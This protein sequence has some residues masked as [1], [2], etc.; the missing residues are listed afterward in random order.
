MKGMT[1]TRR[2]FLNAVSAA[3]FAGSSLRFLCRQAE[4]A[5]L[6]RFLFAYTSA[7]R[8]F[9]SKSTGTGTSFTLGPGLAALEPFK[10][11]ISVV[12]GLRIPDHVE[13]EHPDGRSSMLTGF[14][15]NGRRG[16]GT[17]IDRYLAN[18]LTAGASVYTGAESPGGN[19]DVP[20]SWQANTVANEG[21]TQGSAALLSKLLGGSAP[22]S[23]P[24]VTTPTTPTAP[25]GPSAAQLKAKNEQALYDHLMAQVKSLKNVAPKAELE[26]IEL[27]ITAL[28]QARSVYDG[29]A[30]GGGGT[31][32][33][34]GGGGDSTPV[35]PPGDCSMPNIG[36]ASNESEKLA[37]VMAHAFACGRSRIGVVRLGTEEPHHDWSHYVA[38]NAEYEKLR[39]LDKT[40][41]GYFAKLL[42][43]LDSF[44]EGSGTVLDNTIVVW[45]SEVSGLFG[46]EDIHDVV[47]M[48]VLLAGGLGGKIKMGQRIVAQGRYTMELYRAI[49]RAMGAGDAMD[50]GDSK[51]SNKIL[52]DVLA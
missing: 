2:R 52:E 26:K 23:P 42:G 32:P 21:F 46:S 40:E 44:K 34:P 33:T 17:S 6:P 29:A 43:Y 13:E 18:K 27:H 12:D 4:G 35:T 15:S 45:S 47:N 22:S 14:R 19:I 10:S 31:S 5:G 1:I 37:L 30:T 48:P 39:D 20:I 3:T 7:G 25:S 16:G 24:V 36:S 28:T 9:D 8:H 50:Y 38:G 49:S 51:I 11:K 41:A